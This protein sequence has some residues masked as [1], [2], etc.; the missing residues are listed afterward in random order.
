M[1][2]NWK[3]LLASKQFRWLWAGNVAMYCAFS[4]TLLL[5]SLLAWRLTDD[6]MSLAY[7]N[8]VT[9]VCLFITSIF[10]GAVVDRFERRTLLLVGHCLLVVAE[11]VI[12][13]LLVM[14]KLTFSFLLLS[15]FAVSCTFSFAMPARTAMVVNSVGRPLFGKATAM[16]AGGI[17]IA[18]MLSPAVAGLIADF[19]GIHYGYGY[20]ISLHF[21]GLICSL[22]LESNRPPQEQQR[23]RFLTE[24][25]DGFRYIFG[26][27]PLALCILF[28]LLPILVVIPF[29]NLMVVVVEKLW[30]MGGSGMG[31]MMGAM[32]TGGLLGSL[33]MAR[34]HERGLVKPMV[35]STLVMGVLMVLLSQTPWFHLGLLL[36]MG[37]YS[38]SVLT[39]ALVHT[40]IQLMAD[41]KYRG[42]VT[43]MTVM[44]IGMAP[45]GTLPLAYAIKTIGPALGLSIVALVMIVAVLL[46][47]LA[48]PSFRKIDDVARV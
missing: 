43:T 14:E 19:G 26:N 10:S 37:V 20:L 2:D 5:R 1:I 16:L 17:N 23:G 25:A 3:T 34:V 15:A 8:L 18:R 21:L 44:T 29:Q 30:G 4:A 42:R 47:W 31:L 11:S 28:G 13:Y 35:L 45:V 27:K 12:L 22:M 24:I 38:A 40:G 48:L 33:L 36:T 39:Q 32:G 46:M 7:I 41:E 9:A 6:E